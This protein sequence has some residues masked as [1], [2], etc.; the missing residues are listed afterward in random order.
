M[1]LAVMGQ[2]LAGGGD[3]DCGIIGYG[4]PGRREVLSL[5]AGSRGWGAELRVADCD[6]AIET[7][8]GRPGPICGGTRGGGFEVGQYGR[9]GRVIVPC[10]VI[11]E[12]NIGLGIEQDEVK[13]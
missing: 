9:E 8:G 10:L 12:M 2:N 6:N 4:F 13:R 7:A 11:N 1:R 5:C 3:S